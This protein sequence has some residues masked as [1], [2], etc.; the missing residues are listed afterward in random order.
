M[1]F[2]A[3]NPN[4]N[5]PVTV[6]FTGGGDTATVDYNEGQNNVYL[7]ALTV[8]DNDDGA[9]LVSATFTLATTDGYTPAAGQIESVL[10]ALSTGAGTALTHV[11]DGVWSLSGLTVSQMNTTLGAL[12]FAPGDSNDHDARI[13]VVITDT[14]TD[15]GA[16][17]TDTAYIN[18]NVT[19]VND[20]PE[21]TGAPTAITFTQAN[22][23]GGVDIDTITVT[24]RDYVDNLTVTVTLS[25]TGAGALT[26]GTGT[27]SSTTGVWTV[28]GSQSVVQTAL[29]ALK[30]MPNASSLESVTLAVQVRD[31]QGFAAEGTEYIQLNFSA[32]APGVNDQMTAAFSGGGLTA[33]VGYNEG[34]NVVYIPALTVSDD[35]GTNVSAT[36]TLSL[37]SGTLPAGQTLEGFVGTL[38]S[39]LGSPLVDSGDGRW[40]LS[41]VSVA[42]MNQTL[43]GLQFTPGDYNDL[44]ARLTIE[45]SDLV[46]AGDTGSVTQVSAVVNL[47]V[48]AI[49]DQPTFSDVPTT[50]SYQ[51]DAGYVSIQQGTHKIVVQDHDTGET[52]SVTLKLS[53]SSTGRLRIGAGGSQATELTIEGTT[54]VVNAQLATLQFVPT[55]NN[56]ESSYITVSVRD[57]GEDG[58]G[59]VYQRIDL[60]ATPTPDPLVISSTPTTTDMT[61]DAIELA[62]ISL[63]DL[64]GNEQVTVTLSADIGRYY[65]S[66]QRDGV[67]DGLY[68]P[69]TGKWEITG[70]LTQVN[71]ALA[72]VMFVPDNGFSVPAG[73]DGG[74]TVNV[75]IKDETGTTK[76]GKIW[77][78]NNTS[79]FEML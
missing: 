25:D 8:S 79:F 49:N 51:E 76:N 7:P 71:Q 13:T 56:A 15:G 6:S 31:T 26:G 21:I 50:I 2:S 22:V 63:S 52:V 12:R 29:N 43:A 57:G 1:N 47:N 75:Q 46:K 58:R 54:D 4:I 17:T 30:F 10:G 18:L 67:M 24:D 5:D 77:I 35:D 32:D 36:F 20:L 41:G 66:I 33:T 48:T 55:A 72:D 9:N 61:A 14:A 44:N 59:I 3:D 53:D 37:Q 39:Y 16:A 45:V 65:A 73:T 40:S 69:D 28:S 23:S 60:A 74:T 62:D 68:D 27:Y 11:S 34:V 78:V 42:Q 19:P 38:S 64:D 70:S